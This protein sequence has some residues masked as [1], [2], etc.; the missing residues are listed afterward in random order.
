[1]EQ[2]STFVVTQPVSAQWHVGRI[3]KVTR[4]TRATPVPSFVHE[5]TEPYTGAVPANALEV[6]ATAYAREQ[7]GLAAPA[8]PAPSYH[9][10]DDEVPGVLGITRA[11]FD[12]IKAT[13]LFP[14][15]DAKALRGQPDVNG[16]VQNVT[17]EVSLYKRVD[18]IRFLESAHMLAAMFAGKGR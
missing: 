7:A 12:A 5:S 2:T 14:A 17:A 15:A 13:R 8:A 9:V 6:D 10:A 4:V 11:Q 3:V 1:M 18:V 16:V